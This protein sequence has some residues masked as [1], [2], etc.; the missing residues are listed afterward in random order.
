MRWEREEESLIVSRA[1]DSLPTLPTSSSSSVA[2]LHS[3]HLLQDT[4]LILEIGVR[5]SAASPLHYLRSQ[6]VFLCFSLSLL[7][8]QSDFLSGFTV[9]KMMES[10]A[11]F[12]A[13]EERIS[14]GSFF[15]YPLSGFRASP[16]RSPCPPSDRE[17]FLFSLFFLNLFAICESV[18]AWLLWIRFFFWTCC[19]STTS[20]VSLCDWWVLLPLIGSVFKNDSVK[21]VFSWT[22]Y[23]D[24]NSRSYS[25]TS[26]CRLF[27]N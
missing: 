11:G 9:L 22:A 26:T 17:R 13:M 10:G 15:Q 19:F 25:L 8:A 5:S 27:H 20:S 4:F 2:T 24:P 1:F 6:L 12:V 14:P 21:F 3:P 18:L 7:Y 23:T 16:N